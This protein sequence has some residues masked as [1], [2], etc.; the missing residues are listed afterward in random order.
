[1]LNLSGKL[2][3]SLHVA[4]L[5]ASTASGPGLIPYFPPHPLSGHKLLIDN[6]F[7]SI[8]ARSVALQSE[9]RPQLTWSSNSWKSWACLEMNEPRHRSLLIWNGEAVSLRSCKT[10]LAV[11]VLRGVESALVSLGP[12]TIEVKIT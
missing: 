6:H 10:V 11:E 7:A 3:A 1:V 12:P 4:I 9:Y 2:I 8:L 5:S